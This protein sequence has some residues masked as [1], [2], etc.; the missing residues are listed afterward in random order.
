MEQRNPDIYR[1]GLMHT[2]LAYF[3]WGILPVYWK[4]IDQVGAEEIL[5]HRVFWSFLFMMSLIQINKQW[6]QLLEVCKRMLKKPLL[7]VSLILSSVLISINWFLYIWAVNNDHILETSLG[8]YINP[9]ISVLLGMVFLKERLNKWQ[10]ASFILAAAGVLFMTMQYG[11]FP[12]VAIILA[13]SFG[14]YGLTKKVTKLNA[15]IG[16]TLETMMVMPVAL[17]YLAVIAN[18]GESAFFEWSL[19]TNA[20]L[21]GAGIVTAVPLL[22]FAKGAQHIPLFMVGILQYIA[23]TIT[24]LLGVLIYN[25]SFTSTEII[26]FSLIW[27]AL[28]LFSFSHVRG[29]KENA[30]KLKKKKTM[31]M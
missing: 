21:I 29:M 4:L 20:F 11:R 6:D 1:T 26:T 17:I 9:L 30:W 15:S 31:E 14:F 12:F 10:Y 5:A 13:M 3:L 23:P 25:E 22:L 19:G 16:L 24:L 18:K 28:V 2:A 27:S 7:L 8:Y